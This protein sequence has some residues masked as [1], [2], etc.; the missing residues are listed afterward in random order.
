MKR[1]DFVALLFS[2]T[3]GWPLVGRAQEPS[4]PVIG[5][6]SG[7][8]QAE[9]TIDLSAFHRGLGE[10][11][12]FATRNVAV[13]YRWADGDYN[14]L[15]AFAAELVRQEVSVIAAGGLAPALAAKA[16]TRKTPIIFVVGDDPVRAGLVSSLNSPGSNLTGITLTA[17]PL[18]S[19]RLEL[20]R[21]MIPTI[22]T[23]AVLINPNNAVAEEDTMTAQKA[24]HSVGLNLVVTSAT[25]EKHFDDIFEM[26]SHARI[27]A[28][29]VNTDAFFTSRRDLLVAH[30][31]R[32]SIPAI[33]PF[34]HYTAAG[35]LMSYGPS[36]S[37]AYDQVGRY[38]G[39]ILKGASPAES[40]VEQAT[41]FE[42]VIN[43]RTAQTL[44]LT[45]PPTLLARADELIE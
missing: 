40:P 20:V 32:H 10:A 36:L 26:L 43:L 6:L 28:L 45:V 39:K 7:R 13:E 37:N 5:F 3:A 33:Y 9:S 31:A 44:G 17:G 30:A 18:P 29:I 12:Y 15:P 42:L 1:R 19:K 11:G 27:G 22:K 23:V 34:R 4:M 16:A 38:I 24:A 14:R 35:G 8:S 41:R 21:E 25:S 2:A